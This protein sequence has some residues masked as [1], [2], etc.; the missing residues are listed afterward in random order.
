MLSRLALP[1]DVVVGLS[2]RAQLPE[3][4]LRLLTEGNRGRVGH[5]M[6]TMGSMV[7]ILDSVAF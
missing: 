3:D 5:S 6:A 4:I 7:L 2:L 1:D